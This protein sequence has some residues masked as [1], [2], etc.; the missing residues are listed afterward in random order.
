VALVDTAHR[1]GI[2]HVTTDRLAAPVVP[3]VEAML[4]DGSRLHVVIPDI[5]ASAL[6]RRPLS[7]PDQS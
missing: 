7:L 4:P 6:D 5:A 2:Q 1:R 3:F